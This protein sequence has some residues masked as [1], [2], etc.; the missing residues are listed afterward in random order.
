MQLWRL[1]TFLILPRHGRELIKLQFNTAQIII[2][3][4]MLSVLDENTRTQVIF[5]LFSVSNFM[6]NLVGMHDFLLHSLLFC[7]FRYNIEL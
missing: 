1:G 7:I 4:Y 5:H 6:L 2:C 3:V